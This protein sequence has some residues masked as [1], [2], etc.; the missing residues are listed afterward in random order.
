MRFEPHC[1]CALDVSAG[2]S[3]RKAANFI[4]APLEPDRGGV[5]VVGESSVGLFLASDGVQNGVCDGRGRVGEHGGMTALCRVRDHGGTREGALRRARRV[6]MSDG[7]GAGTRENGYHG[8][9]REGMVGRASHLGTSVGDGAGMRNPAWQ[10]RG[11]S[12]RRR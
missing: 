7:N 3:L 10:W 5:G 2:K 1:S 4:S 6:G 12:A 9:A 8:G 11:G